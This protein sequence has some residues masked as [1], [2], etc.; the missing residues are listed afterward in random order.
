M[1]NIG[2]RVVENGRVA[3][4]YSPGYGSGW[5]TWNTTHRFRARCLFDPVIVQWVR[6]GKPSVQKNLMETYLYDVY[7]A[8]FYVGTNL[9]SLE[10]EWIPQGTQ[11]IVEEYDGSESIRFSHDVQWITA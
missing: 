2:N 8:D 7:G 3:V 6:D 10:I 9:D 1:D 11:F 5:S 4:L